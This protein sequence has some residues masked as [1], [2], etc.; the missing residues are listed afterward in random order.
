ME[1]CE[2]ENVEQN[3]KS[4]VRRSASAGGG[5]TE[6]IP[7]GLSTNPRDLAHWGLS[8]TLCQSYARQGIKE[9]Y[10]WQMDA[11]NQPKVLAGGNLVYSAPT[12]GGKTLVAEI[13]MLRNI[14]RTRKKTLFVLPFVSIVVEKMGYFKK[15]YRSSKIKVKGFYSNQGG[16]SIDRQT[17]VAVCTIEKANKLVNRLLESNSLHLLSCVILDEMH[18]VG[19]GHRGYLLELL[20]TKIR[21]AV[22]RS[23]RRLEEVEAGKAVSPE[24]NPVDIQ[25]I[26]LSAT[27]PNLPDLCEWLDAS[28]FVTKYRP[29]PLTEFMVLGDKVYDRDGQAV[30]TLKRDAKVPR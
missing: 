15:V 22:S 28:M 16:S 9:L 3:K 11:I 2:K 24:Q 26:G 30:R 6:P 29:V 23:K 8:P 25:V 12:G 13:L 21:F 18:L 19:D 7:V 14:Q 27:L 5:V 17:K 4:G 1:V 20:L 10:Q